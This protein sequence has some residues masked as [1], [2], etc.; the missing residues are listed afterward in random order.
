MSGLKA[1]EELVKDSCES[2]NKAIN[3]CS[4]RLKDAVQDG[5]IKTVQ[6]LSTTC[7][8]ISVASA[9]L[10]ECTVSIHMVRMAKALGKQ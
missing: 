6:A 4:I 2:M 9:A 8:A 3:E 10:R 5:D 1:I 7:A